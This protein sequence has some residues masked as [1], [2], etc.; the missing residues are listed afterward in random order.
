MKKENKTPEPDNPVILSANQFPVVGIGA[1]A[2]GLEAFKKFIKAIPEHSGMAFVLVQHLDPNHDSVLTELLQKVTE[3]PVCEITDHIK[4]LRDHI[5]IIP[6]NKILV[7]NDGI[8]KLSP[9]PEKSKK[10]L[11]LPIDIFFTSLAEIH[12]DHAIGVV[13]SG[14]AS[15]GT[16]GL[17]A[18][19]LNG[20]I[21]FAQDEASAAY[22]GMPKSASQAGVV[23]FVL[24]PEEMPAKILEIKNKAILTDE[25]LN[26]MVPQEENIFRRILSL[27]LVR[28]GTDFTY[29]KQTTI[30]RRILR[31]MA[32]NKTEQTAEY[33]K[34][35]KENVKEQDALYQDLLIPVTSF[36]R[37][38]TV[39]DHLCKNVFPHIL[40]NKNRDDPMRVW[41][42]GCST[43]EEAYSM[44]ICLLEFLDDKKEKIQIFATD[45]SEPAILKARSGI[46]TNADVTGVSAERLEKFF[47]K[48]ADG[49][50]ISKDVR[51]LCVFAAH[52]FLKDPPFGK[53]DFVSCRNVLIYMEPYLQKKALTTFHYALNPG[54]LLLL[55]KSETGNSVPLLFEFTD[56]QD[57][58][59]TRKDAPGKF[60]HSATIRK[61]ASLK[62]DRF[63]TKSEAMQID[64]Q[65]TADDLLLSR[66][67]PASVVVNDA[68][69]IVHFRG[70]TALYLEQAPG[71]PT[72]NLL[73]MARTGLAFELRNV[74][75]KARK[76]KAGVISENIPVQIGGVQQIVS[77][78]AVPLPEQI[79]PYYLVI[80][81]EV[82]QS[83]R[84]VMADADKDMPDDKELLIMQMERELAQV[85]EDMRSITEDQEAANEELQSANEELLSS[86]EELQSVNEEMESSKEELQSTN[87]ELTVLNQEL[88]NLN[89]QVSEGQHYSDSI[90]ATVRESLII[91]DTKL[92]IKTANL[93]FYSTFRVNKEET[94]G[95]LIYNLGNKQWDIPA[96]R[97]LL[98]EVLPQQQSFSDF[99]ITHNFPEIGER[100]MLLNG[101][102]I[103]GQ[104]VE[105]KLILLSIDDITERKAAENIL[106]QSEEMFREIADKERQAKNHFHF[107]ADAMPQKVWTADAA[108]NVNYFNKCWLDYTGLSFEEL[109]DWGWEKIVHK[110]DWEENK[111]LWLH[112]INTGE[113]FEFE[114]RFLKE[115]GEYKWH[116]SRGLA[117]KDDNGKVLMWIGTNTEIQT[118]KEQKKLLEDAVAI[119]TGELEEANKELQHK[120]QEIAI[121]K[122]NKRFLTEFSET[123]SNYKLHTEF[124]NSVVN[125][126]AD[127]THL[128]YVFIGRL[129]ETE[130]HKFYIE[131]IAISAFGKQVD[132]IKYPLPDGPCEQVIRG[133]LYAYAENCRVIFP[134]NETLVQFN[135]EGYLGYPLY[136]SNGEAMGLIAVMHEGKIV[137]VETVSSVLKIVAKRAEME[138]ERMHQEENLKKNNEALEDKNNELL[139]MNKELESFSYISSHDLQEP[140]RKIQTFSR[141]ILQTEGEVISE[142]GKD[143]FKR[144]TNAAE[145]MQTL[146]EDLLTYSRTNI[147]ERIFKKTNLNHILDDVKEELKELLM[148]N[149]AEIKAGD[150][151]EAD[152]IPFQF[153]QVL[154]NLITNSVKFSN[155]GVSPVISIKNKCAEAT[156]LQHE[157]QGSTAGDILPLVPGKTYCRFTFTDNGIGFDPQYKQKIFE[158]FQR[159]HGKEEYA[160]TG[161]GLA[162]IKKIVE[163]HNGFINAESELG[164][165]ATFNIYLPL[166]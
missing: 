135:V 110:D 151:G 4:V 94:K 158:V 17:K 109:R 71:K 70:N 68:M 149:N 153:R 145:R 90:V 69:D 11:N 5:Y 56:K 144:M 139:R 39:F 41:V 3:I 20:G 78:E 121:S 150:L 86:S 85:R 143:Y 132:N 129:K 120:N 50:R 126:V 21:T 101:R 49:Y 37:D 76:L 146:I 88:V 63:P 104:G 43:G 166:H 107:I 127:L 123:F 81:R 61:E 155:P 25:E 154:I 117:H 164:K 26:E 159:L 12:R 40:K 30:R 83:I 19:K 142:A 165:G 47:I 160:G 42:V 156:V 115:N 44:A 113:N 122:Y 134:K 34:Y 8:L 130:D 111:R 52:N 84:G 137:D 1:S 87:E 36:F 13:L 102:E 15:D 95:L 118:Q 105:G 27:L 136:N 106:K 18:I 48:R 138:L 112:S 33:L 125:Y 82:L 2:G 152:I 119:R 75:Q 97:K 54:S 131:T 23:D 53:I 59:F 65:Q 28:K 108:G 58:I 60:I 22:D 79:D 64:F 162:I 128:D 62:D 55:G 89:I 51:D 24:P 91:L 114:H 93:S 103:H 6:S 72:H 9:R 163:N 32:I 10:E 98:E 140:L 29:Y 38:H 116:L 14:T 67:T 99:E 74:I 148:Q 141:L 45:I 80:F 46:Y 57:K 100:V 66:Y 133:E 147:K 157:N 16:L 31:R 7:A 35:L 96:L 161:I 124:F 73:K 77:I 92:R